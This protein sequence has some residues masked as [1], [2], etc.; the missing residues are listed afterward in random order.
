MPAGQ[1]AHP[2]EPAGAHVPA[3]HVPQ[4]EEFFA[5]A[6]ALAVPAG[7][8][9]HVALRAI[10]PYEPG[11]HGAQD[12]CPAFEN[13]PMG[14]LAQVVAAAAPTVALAVPAAQSVHAID[15]PTETAVLYDP[16]VH[17]VH[18]AAP[19]AAANVPAGQTTHVA[20][21]VAPT[22][23]EAVPA[24]HSEHDA[25]PEA[26]AYDPAAHAAQ[27]P[28]PTL[29]ANIPKPQGMQVVATV[30]PTTEEAVPT[31]HPVHAAAAVPTLNDPAA[32]GVHGPPVPAL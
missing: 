3:L 26:A 9:T 21:D 10:G 6:T 13:A 29:N 28:L 32:Q 23:A 5:P 2:P 22:T 15:P 19:G 18:E 14:Q 11:V 27:V 17:E 25:V 7:H 30:E 1:L 24:A 16:A 4:T 31:A 20:D 8:E 12:A